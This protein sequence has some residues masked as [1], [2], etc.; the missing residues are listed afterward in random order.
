MT[1]GHALQVLIFED[2]V[3]IVRSFLRSRLGYCSWGVPQKTPD[4]FGAYSRV[5][6][7]AHPC[8]QTRGRAGIDVHT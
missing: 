6:F 3:G 7:I 1:V 2:R 8:G 4:I 5:D